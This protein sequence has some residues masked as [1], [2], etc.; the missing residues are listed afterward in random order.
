VNSWL[1]A[2]MAV[3]G[4]LGGGAG[5]YTLLTIGP[6]KRKIAAEAT[7][8]KASADETLADAVKVLVGGAADLVGP[9]KR[10]LGEAR[11]ELSQTRGEVA[12]LQRD[13][14]QLEYRVARLIDMIHD[15]Y[16]DLDRLRVM[17]P[18]PPGSSNG[19]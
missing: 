7:H 17:V 2:L 6:A 4:A 19:R 18:L 5:V 16:M 3:V 15:P 11:A 9:L 13:C 1:A 12:K 10:E 8:I 14:T